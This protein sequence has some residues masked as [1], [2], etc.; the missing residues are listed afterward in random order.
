MLSSCYPRS[1]RS[2]TTTHNIRKIALPLALY[3]KPKLAATVL[4][5]AL[6]CVSKQQRMQENA[7]GAS[8]ENERDRDRETE[9]DKRETKIQRKRKERDK[10]QQD[11]HKFN[12]RNAPR[13]DL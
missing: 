3:R 13:A 8:R 1:R 4:A 6:R 9:R 2:D 10:H 5:T 11:K 7:L 12:K